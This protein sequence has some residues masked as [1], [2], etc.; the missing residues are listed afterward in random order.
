MFCFLSI[1]C[2]TTG[3]SGRDLDVK[4]RSFS[5][6]LYLLVVFGLSW[7]F[8]IIAAIWGVE[9]LPRYILHAT[10]MFMVTVGTYIC[11]RYIFG[12]GFE[13]AGWHW[14]K[15]RHYLLV[16]GLLIFLMVV[17]TI[18]DLVVGTV[19]VPSGLTK[20]QVV[21]IFV[22]LLFFVP[23][24]G[25]E[26]GWRGYML[27][28]LAER[29]SPRKAVFLH[30][31]IWWAWHWPVLV[32]VGTHMGPGLAEE[33]GVSAGLAV[34]IVVVSTVVASAIPAIL[35]AEVIGYIWSRSSSLAVAT[36]YHLWYDGVRDSIHINIGAGPIMGLWVVFWLSVLGII[37]LWK[38]NWENLKPAGAS[39]SEDVNYANQ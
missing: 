12:D 24:F 16:I 18:I 8:Q 38:G 28:R 7:P 21:W 33:M 35:H 27:P 29:Y 30:G 14:G 1:V 37:F 26:F 11:G 17:P 13:G 32:G 9:L 2:D 5:L 23:A 36:V 6:W 22:G 20:V 25:E 3:M 15:A 31:I 19:K 39:T 4:R 34:L 10:S